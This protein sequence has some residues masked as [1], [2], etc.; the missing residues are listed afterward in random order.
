MLDQQIKRAAFVSG[1][2]GEALTSLSFTGGL[3]DLLGNEIADLYQP[4]GRLGCR[5]TYSEAGSIL[6][7]E[8]P[9]SCPVPIVDKAE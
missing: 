7:G 4:Q 5:S 1:P 3:L 8:H 6:E 2:I 9:I